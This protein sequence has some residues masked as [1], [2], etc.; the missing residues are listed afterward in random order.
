MSIRVPEPTNPVPAK[1]RE[2]MDKLLAKTDSEDIKHQ[3]LFR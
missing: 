3:L 1:M 2:Y